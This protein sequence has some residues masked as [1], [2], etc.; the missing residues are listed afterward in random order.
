MS[1]LIQAEKFPKFMKLTRLQF[2]E[3]NMNVG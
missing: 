2:Q 3:I 1:V